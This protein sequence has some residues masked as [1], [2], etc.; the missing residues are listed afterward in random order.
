MMNFS[1]WSEIPTG[2]IGCFSLDCER[3][4]VYYTDYIDNNWLYHRLDGPAIIFPDGRESYCVMSQVYNKKE[5]WNH[6]LVIKH[7]MNHLVELDECP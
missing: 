5:Y 7:L 4:A 1:K 2:F 6:P 3:G